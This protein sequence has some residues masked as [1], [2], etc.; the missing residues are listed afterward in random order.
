MCDKRRGALI[1]AITDVVEI[2]WIIVVNDERAAEVRIR[3]SSRKRGSVVVGRHDVN[4]QRD[5]TAKGVDRA[6]LIVLF[7]VIKGEANLVVEEGL[8]EIRRSRPETLPFRF[9]IAVDQILV[10][11][12]DRRIGQRGI[13]KEATVGERQPRKDCFLGFA[14]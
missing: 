14:V 10:E 7:V 13:R 1:F 2:G 8:R 9:H 5:G 4:E 12:E 11:I 6:V 3:A